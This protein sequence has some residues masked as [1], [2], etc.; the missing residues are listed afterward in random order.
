MPYDGSGNPVHSFGRGKLNDSMRSN[1]TKAVDPK[2]RK[3]GHQPDPDSTMEESSPEDIHDVVKEHGP[4]TAM[5]YDAKNDNEHH[6]TS[7]HGAMKHHSK[8]GSRGEAMAHMHAAMG[9]DEKNEDEESPETEMAEEKM[10]PHKMSHAVPG[11]V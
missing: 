11:L 7:H 9:E 5:H 1:S 8:H 3:S 2:S 6:V 10:Q 4:A